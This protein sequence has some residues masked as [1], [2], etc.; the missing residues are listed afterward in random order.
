MPPPISQTSRAY[1]WP[2]LLILAIFAASSMSNLA[3]PD[4][5][6]R[7]SKDKLAHFLV[8]GLVATSILRTPKLCNLRAPSLLIAIALT[9][10]YGGCD[11]FRQSLT[12]GRSVEFADWIAD[13]TGAIVAAIIYAKWTAYRKFLE[14]PVPKMR[15][16]QPKH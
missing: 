16:P 7:F 1:L 5:D 11:E 2:I 6:L 8:F 15:K 12:P 3:T 14:W 9:S 10:A 4:I 13:T